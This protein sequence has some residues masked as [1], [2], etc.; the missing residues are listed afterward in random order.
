MA[1]DPAVLLASSLFVPLMA[2][3]VVGYL[4]VRL[5]RAKPPLPPID[6]SFYPIFIPPMPPLPKVGG[7]GI[8]GP[9][10]VSNDIELWE[11][12]YTDPPPEYVEALLLCKGE[13]APCS[14]LVVSANN[15][16][17][18]TPA[19]YRIIEIDRPRGER[20][21]ELLRVYFARDVRDVE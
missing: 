11:V 7:M 3:L 13:N 17:F 5:H 1:I 12:T 18:P 15:I 9:K 2:G 6:W 20:G 14:F 8:D 19:S 16:P 21:G 10:R 4:F